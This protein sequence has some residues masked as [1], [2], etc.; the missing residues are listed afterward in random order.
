MH[1]SG[2]QGIFI[3]LPLGLVCDPCSAIATYLVYPRVRGT[4][5]KTRVLPVIARGFGALLS[6]CFCIPLSCKRDAL[7]LKELA[8]FSLA[9]GWYWLF[10]PPCQGGARARCVKPFRCGCLSLDVIYHSRSLPQC[11]HRCRNCFVTLA[12]R[13]F[14]FVQ[15]VILQLLIPTAGNSDGGTRTP[16]AFRYTAIARKCVLSFQGAYQEPLGA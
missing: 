4:L 13:L 5:Y 1:R 2:T 15:A 6:H 16:L 3:A 10:S 8:A 12:A 11:Q 14:G 9:P 7:T